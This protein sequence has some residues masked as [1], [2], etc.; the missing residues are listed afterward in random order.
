MNLKHKTSVATLIAIKSYF[1]MKLLF[2]RNCN[3]MSKPFI[4]LIPFLS[5][6]SCHTKSQSNSDKLKG[7]ELFKETIPIFKSFTK[8]KEK[9][10][11]SA[12]ILSNILV[13]KYQIIYQLD[14]T[15]KSI[16]DFFSDCYKFNKEYEKQIFWDRHQLLLNT[17]P[18]DKKVYFEN[19]ATAYLSLGILDSCKL[20]FTK[21]FHL[22][23]E[24][25]SKF[26][27]VPEFQIITE[28]KDFADNIYLKQDKKGLE[29]LSKRIASTCQY[30]VEILKFILPYSND[31]KVILQK[32]FNL[33]TI[34]DREK[35]CR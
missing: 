24:V 26:Q 12:K 13:D 11:D 19:L 18:L 14:S 21:A 32:P 2:I 6:L 9:N 27:L 17:K 29:I 16:G 8:L 23:K 3:K 35:N 30:S 33:D 34:N 31:K 10:I 25:D 1:Y 15:S 20:Y 28:F 7:Q 5:L 4:F 22:E